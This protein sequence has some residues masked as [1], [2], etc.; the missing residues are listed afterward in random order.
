[1][2]INMNDYH[3]LPGLSA[4]QLNLLAKSPAHYKA[5]LDGQLR[6]DS[7]A[8]SLGS[9]VHLRLESKELFDQQYVLK[10]ADHDGRTKNGK[11]AVAELLSNGKEL[12]TPDELDQV[13]SIVKRYSDC[14]D[15]LV[16]IARDGIGINETTVVW[17]ENNRAMKCRPDRLIYPDDESCDWL[18]DQ[19]PMLFSTPFGISI[20]VDFKTTSR[21]P[22][23]K[24][25]YWHSRE[26]G[27]PLAASHYL[28]GTNA[29]AFLWIVFE[30]NP[31]YTITRYLL[32]PQTKELMD[33]RRQEL[34]GLLDRCEKEKNWPALTVSN[35]DTLV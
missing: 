10:T 34:I 27:Y 29:D 7:K 23:P 21:F 15:R 8:M 28:T 25:W 9:K 32:S 1:M 14:D 33:Q 26:F 6:F 16:S 19:F 11:A 30:V 13:E 5:S 2:K 17:E 20:C 31:P 22:D 3:Q 24:N 35:D 12:I 18:C 4:S